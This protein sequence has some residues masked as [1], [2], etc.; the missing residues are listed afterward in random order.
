MNNGGQNSN[1]RPTQITIVPSV[2]TPEVYARNLA[3]VQ[4]ARAA[5]ANFE[6]ANAAGYTRYRELEQR[7]R[8]GFEAQYVLYFNVMPSSSFTEHTQTEISRIIQ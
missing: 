8:D 3:Q 7:A 6:A 2:I 5:L 4:E 1:T